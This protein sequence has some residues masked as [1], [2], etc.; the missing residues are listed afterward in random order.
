[1]DTSSLDITVC[2]QDYP[3]LSHIYQFFLCHYLIWELFHRTCA[4]SKSPAHLLTM[5]PSGDLNDYCQMTK[6]QGI[7]ENS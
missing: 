7:Q 2:Q 1:M 4:Y 6:L 5:C 3:C